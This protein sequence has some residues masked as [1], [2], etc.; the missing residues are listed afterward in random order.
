MG[1]LLF[2]IYRLPLSYILRK[3]GVNFYC[4]ADDTQL[5]GSFPPPSLPSCLVEIKDWL[6]ANLEAIRVGT[7]SVSSKSNSFF[8]YI[9]NNAISPS[10]RVKS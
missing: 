1:P 5:H 2:I 3:H 6:S 10:S 9:D 8:L 7:R 4:Y